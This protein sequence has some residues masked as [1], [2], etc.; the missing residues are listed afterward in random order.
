MTR[1]EKVISIFLASP[2]DLSDERERLAEV[3]QTWNTTSSRHFGQRLELRRWESDA[4]PGLGTDPQAVINKQIPDDCDIFIGIMWGR[5]GTPTGRAESG[6]LEEFQRVYERHKANPLSVQVLFYFK[7]APIP[8]SKL[9]PAQLSKVQEFKKW[10]GARG[11]YFEFNDADEFAKLVGMHLTKIAHESIIPSVGPPTPT[12]AT[13]TTAAAAESAN[14]RVVIRGESSSL[15]SVDEEEP[16]AEL[17]Y[18]ELLEQFEQSSAELTDIAARMTAAELELADRITK[19]AEQINVLVANP[20]AATRGQAKKLMTLIAGEMRHFTRRIEAEIPLF[21]GA[22]D[23][24]INSLA[25]L[26]TLSFQFDP[27]QTA[28]A[29]VAGSTLLDALGTAREATGRFRNSTAN[30]PPMTTEV[31]NS[32]RKQIS[33]LDNLLGEFTRAENLLTEAISVMNALLSP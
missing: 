14:D 4:Y 25:K 2:G 10:L 33:A 32:R 9:D 30:L 12:P 17:G 21:R 19:L 5:V 11:V 29:R 13:P 24:S 26:A 20:S 28:N 18:L 31:I 6:T 8:P 16:E 15:L 27:N 22:L 3:I 1:T 7:D 23:G